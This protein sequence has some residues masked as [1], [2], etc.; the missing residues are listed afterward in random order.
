MLDVDPPKTTH[1]LMQK[2]AASSPPPQPYPTKPLAISG[3]GKPKAVSVGTLVFPGAQQHASSFL[4]KLYN[5]ATTP[6]YLIPAEYVEYLATQRVEML[7]VGLIMAC[8]LAVMV[9]EMWEVV[10]DW[11]VLCCCRPA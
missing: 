5:P 2:T 4:R 9:V 1:E 8:V 10:A 7:M 3:L 6:R 11:Y